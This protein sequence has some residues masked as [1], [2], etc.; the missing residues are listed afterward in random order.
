MPAN[1]EDLYCATFTTSYWPISIK[2]TA[3]FK[4]AVFGREENSI[5]LK[6]RIF[7]ELNFGGEAF[8]LIVI[9]KERAPFR[10]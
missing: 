4:T 1:Y 7:I 9:F 3:Y 8:I 5:C 2:I 10:L 6:A